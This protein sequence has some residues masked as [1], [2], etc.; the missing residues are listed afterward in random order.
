M[1][2]FPESVT[3]VESTHVGPSKCLSFAAN[4]SISVGNSESFHAFGP[5]L[6]I[7]KKKN[8]SFCIFLLFYLLRSYHKIHEYYVSHK[9]LNIYLF[10]NFNLF[11]Y[12]FEFKNK[13]TRD[14][15][16]QVQQWHDGDLGI[17]FQDQ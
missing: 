15:V 16:D 7:K 9:C 12:I 5:V 6:K 1:Y 13:H 17:Y 3:V 4:S 2:V 8:L 11:T 14:I 10:L